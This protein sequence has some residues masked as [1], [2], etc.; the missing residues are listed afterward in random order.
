MSTKFKPRFKLEPDIRSE[1]VEVEM[2]GIGGA[3]R[4]VILKKWWCCTVYMPIE[5]KFTP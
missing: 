3:D 4:K 2:K 1:V 5:V